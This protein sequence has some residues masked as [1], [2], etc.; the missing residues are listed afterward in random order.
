VLVVDRLPEIADA[1]T[2]D[3]HY[4][5]DEKQRNVLLTEEGY[6]AVEDVL[7]VRLD[8]MLLRP[9]TDLNML[10]YNMQ[11]ALCSDS[12][13]GKGQALPRGWLLAVHGRI[14]T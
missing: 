1:L 5:V 7:Q 6:E 13:L 12:I 9:F 14:F 11:Q 4:T 10:S 8:E 3:M 2:K